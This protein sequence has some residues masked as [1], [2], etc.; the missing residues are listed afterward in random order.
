GMPQFFSWAFQRKNGALI[1][2]EVALQAVRFAEERRLIFLIRDITGLNRAALQIRRL[3]SFPALNPDPVIELSPEQEIMYANPATFTALKKLGMPENPAAFLPE[4]IDGITASPGARPPVNHYREVTVGDN[5]YG[6]TI[7]CVPEYGAIRI[8]AHDITD[9]GR[10]M[11]G[12]EQANRKLNLLSSITRHDIKNKLTG[13]LGYLEL[14]LGTTQDPTLLDYLKRAETSANGIRQQIEFTKEYENL[15][16]KSPAWQEITAL[17]A[18]VTT[19]LDLKGIG[20]EDETDGLQ[21][22]ADLMLAKVIYNL[23]ENSVQHGEHVGRIRFTVSAVPEHCTLVYEDDGIGVAAEEKE[24][25]FGRVARTHAGIGLFL[26][27]EILSITG[28][29]ITENGV[30]GSGARFEISIPR[31]KFRIKP[32]D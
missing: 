5:L 4:D 9:R 31:G 2:A 8:Y 32:K 22:Y 29:T 27:R 10:A 24:K 20:V 1:E 16:I 17:I 6:E 12:F 30:P 11:N 28:I 26:V 7:T 15:G 13:V 3:A 18:E 14:S 21:V 19:Q 23:M 25:I